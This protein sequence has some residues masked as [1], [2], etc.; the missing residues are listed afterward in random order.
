MKSVIQEIEESKI[1]IIVRGVKI[2]KLLP[3]ADA[4][5]NGGIKLMEITYTAHDESSDKETAETIRKLA[6][7]T[8]GRMY[9]GAGTVTRKNQIDLTLAA[10]GKFIISPDTDPEIISYTKEVG[11]VSIPGALTPSEITAAHRSGADF[12]KLFPANQM[13]AS[14]LRAIKA[15]L[16]HVK[17]LAVGSMDERTIPEYLAAGASGF[18]IGT[19]FGNPEYLRDSN[20]DAI[21][22][23][24]KEYV[25]KARGEQ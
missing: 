3:L 13:G 5:I 1:I 21:T 19:K 10:G 17:I 15:P 23:V 11:L 20:F 2:E 25:R 7:Y 6:E 16:S 9:I 4:L 12:V 18:G 22:D 24:A 14:Y 8:D